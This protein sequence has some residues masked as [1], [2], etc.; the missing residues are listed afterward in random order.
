MERW[1][2]RGG[3]QVAV[4]YVNFHFDKREERVAFVGC[5][6]FGGV[7][8]TWEEKEISL[9]LYVFSVTH[10]LTLFVLNLKNKK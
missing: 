7:I 6:V 2:G 5:K 8:S 4:N 3:V 1:E 10:F 9:W